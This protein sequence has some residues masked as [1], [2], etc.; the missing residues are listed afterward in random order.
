MA[1]IEERLKDQQEYFQALYSADTR[2][3]RFKE[4]AELLKTMRE[5]IETTCPYKVGDTVYLNQAGLATEG[6]ACAAHTLV[7]GRK[8]IVKSRNF[9]NGN[10]T[11][12]LS[13]ENETWIDTEGKEQPL[14]RPYVYS[15]PAKYISAYNPQKSVNEDSD[16]ITREFNL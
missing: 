2:M 3:S 11:L 9:H 10:F 4:L 16:L 6:W 13:F 1:T 15:I 14:D 12:G 7:V 5:V 8:A